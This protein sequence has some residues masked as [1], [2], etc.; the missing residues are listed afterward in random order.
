MI[1]VLSLDIVLL[2]AVVSARRRLF[3]K[4]RASGMMKQTWLSLP[5]RVVSSRYVA[6]LF[7]RSELI[8]AVHVIH[9]AVGRAISRARVFIFQ[10]RKVIS[11]FKPPSAVIFRMET[12]SGR[13][14]GSSRPASGLKIR[15]MAMTTACAACR[16]MP[17]FIASLGLRRLCCRCIPLPRL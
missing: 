8:S 6:F 10:P 1:R 9:L 15:N 4:W 7:F 17:M 12:G 2:C 14:I 16:T 11:S 13:L 3:M 5:M